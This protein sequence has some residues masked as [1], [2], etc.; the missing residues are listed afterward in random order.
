MSGRDH[1][2]RLRAEL[3]GPGGR[4]P[5]RALSASGQLG[6]GVLE[7]A[8]R[9]GLAR[10]PHAI[11]ADMGSV[12]PGPN[13]LGSGRMAPSDAIA[14]RDLG[15]VLEAARSLDVPLLIGSAGTGGAR[16]HLDHT[17]ALVREIARERGLHFRLASIA[18]D[19][20]REVVRQAVARGEVRP[21]GAIAP[22]TAEEVD[23]CSHLVGQMGIEAFQ[24]ALATGADVVVAGRACDT[25]VFSAIPAALG[26]PLGP[27]MHMAKIIE[28][29]SIACMP[30]GRDAALG[31]LDE[32]GFTM[33]SL[34]PARHA[35]PLSVA[36]HS[37]Y[38]QA[39]PYTVSEPEGTLHVEDARYVAL[40]EHRCRVEGARWVPAQRPSV[41]IEG[42]RRVGERALLLAG[43]ADP[44][45][46]AAIDRILP[47]VEQ[48]VRGIV[49]GDWKIWFRVYGIDGVVRW[50]TPP[51][52]LPREVFIL[53][54]IIAPT[55]DL[56]K[57]AATVTKQYLLHHG[58]PGRLSTAG[59]VAFPVTPPELMAG[60][61]YRFNVYHVMQVDALE[62]LFP[63]SVEDL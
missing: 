33:E 19:M 1:L 12:D 42:A 14:R 20:P 36:A 56:A 28:C 13:Y 11:G 27:A 25:A 32:T 3:C 22:L 44:R 29:C 43:S 38:E 51:E 62:P 24:R 18:A 53:G 10:A 5:F 15:L 35:T 55:V 60:T 7:P 40:D 59:N 16:P 58:F 4:A 47:E 57:A 54:E 39:D 52:V 48:V 23:A 26:Y 37:L 45:V 41:K 49:A 9:A 8:L 2:A 34:N 21:I 31:T 61:A 6:N 63:V 50:P 30:G 17:L 46:I